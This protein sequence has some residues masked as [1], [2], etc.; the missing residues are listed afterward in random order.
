M[1]SALT[2]LIIIMVLLSA[3]LILSHSVL[4]A[5]DAV[6]ESWREM[7]ERMGE[8][9]R[10]GL[11]PVDAETIAGGAMV[12]VTLRNDGTTKLAD[13]DRWDVVVQYHDT[14]G[15][16]HVKWLPFAQPGDKWTV[17]GLYLDASTGTAEVFEPNVLNPG[18]EIVIQISVSSWVGSPTTNLATV[19]APN[20]I[21]AS[22]VFTY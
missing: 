7:E 8:R 22:T 18:E 9:A 4:S 14:G 10:T 20:G 5:Q 17:K 6:L 2:G 16:Y 19:A 1:E 15:L 21:S 12:D 11:S 13:F 3:I